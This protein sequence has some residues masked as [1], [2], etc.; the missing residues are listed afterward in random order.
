MRF[1]LLTGLCGTLLACGAPDAP[2]YSGAWQS[3]NAYADQVREIPLVRPY[4]YYALPIDTTLKGLLERWAADS[5]IQLD[6]RHAS[7]YTLPP[8]VGQIR[9]AR[10]AEAIA[11]L[12]RI[13]APH[14]VAVSVAGRTMTLTPLTK[15]AASPPTLKLVDGYE[16][17]QRLPDAMP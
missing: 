9:E 10:L 3:V 4:Q 17:G 16:P 14:G 1:L 6:Y 2:N 8:A 5:K 15:T 11:G 13:Y 12:N 7:D